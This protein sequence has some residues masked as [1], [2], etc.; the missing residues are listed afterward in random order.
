MAVQMASL[1]VP[2]LPG[3]FLFMVILD[4]GR[5]SVRARCADAPGVSREKYK[6]EA[7]NSSPLSLSCF[8]WVFLFHLGFPVLQLIMALG[9]VLGHG[10]S[11]E[12]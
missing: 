2:P 11:G 1:V 9:G 6:E 8:P 5:E 4:V 3:L 10:D 7:F 12:S